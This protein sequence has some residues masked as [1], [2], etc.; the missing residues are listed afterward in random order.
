MHG[1]QLEDSLLASSDSDFLDEDLSLD[2]LDGPAFG[3]AL[4]FD[5]LFGFGFGFVFALALAL[6]PAGV[7]ESSEELMS[8]V[9][10]T[11][12]ASPFALALAFP[13]PLPLPF[14]FFPFPF[15]FS[16]SPHGFIFHKV[17]I[18]HH[19]HHHRLP[20]LPKSLKQVEL[21]NL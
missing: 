12:K 3:F 15:P 19:Q 11:G 2:P 13:L 7:V 16:S 21:A 18:H 20:N 14:P 9:P 4:D 6:A 1:V 10:Q 8:L 5:L 17:R